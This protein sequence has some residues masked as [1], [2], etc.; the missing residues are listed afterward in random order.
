M[1]CLIRHKMEHPKKGPGAMN[2]KCRTVVE[3]WQII[4]KCNLI[5]GGFFTGPP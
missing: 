1:E 3:H 2:K 4:P 5:Q